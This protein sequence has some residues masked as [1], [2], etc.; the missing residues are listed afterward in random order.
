MQPISKMPHQTQSYAAREVMVRIGPV[1]GVPA[2]LESL[3]LDPREVL[4]DCGFDIGIFDD[5]DNLISFVARGRL[6]ADCAAKAN[7]PYFGLLIGQHSGL[8]SLGL[9]GLLA[10]HSP[11]VRTA[12]DNLVRYFHLQTRGSM[13]ALHENNGIATLSY[14][15][16]QSSSRANDEVGAG[17]VAIMFNVLQEL[18]GPDWLPREAWFIHQ[19]PLDAEPYRRFFQTHLRF[20]AEQNAIFFLAS[21]LNRPQKA[22]HP[23]LY[24]MAQQ[25]IELLEVQQD[26]NFPDQVRR[27]LPEAIIRGD[28]NADHVAALFSMHPRTLNRHLKAYGTN[29]RELRDKISFT[30]AAQLLNDTDLEI[31]QIATNLSYAD[32]RSFIRAFRRWSGTT[33]ARWRAQQKLL[34]NIEKH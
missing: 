27:V 32:A 9:P 3:G 7:C 12:L 4:A 10:K 2:A 28:S 30:I 6:M 18:C 5:P 15:I 33:P 1:M 24:K 25:Q 21:W 14:H 31:S 11:D 29:F 17:A 34:R 23:D 19:Q 8:N 13:L 26:S 16:R 22:A 20:N